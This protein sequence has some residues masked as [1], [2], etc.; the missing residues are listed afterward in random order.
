M[1]GVRSIGHG[2]DESLVDLAWA[3]RVLNR[4]EHLLK[5]NELAL[6]SIQAG[7]DGLRLTMENKST[8]DKVGCKRAKVVVLDAHG[9]ESDLGEFG[10]LLVCGNLRRRDGR[11]AEADIR[12][13]VAFLNE[14][15]QIVS[16]AL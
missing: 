6:A 14:A 12:R 9:F 2:I 10:R 11:Q 13:W 7:K 5:C 8:F 15:I 16:S 1:A 4:G 3:G